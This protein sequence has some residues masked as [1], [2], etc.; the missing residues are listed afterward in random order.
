[1]PSRIISHRRGM[2]V[3]GMREGNFPVRCL[4][5][6]EE[7]GFYVL[8]SLH[9]CAP[10]PKQSMALRQQHEARSS[11]QFLGTIVCLDGEVVMSDTDIC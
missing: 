9:G 3:D 7:V 5:L 8:R 4:S 2:G 10:V 6:I 1:M 11:D